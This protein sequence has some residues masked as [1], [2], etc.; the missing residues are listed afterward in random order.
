M[1][2]NT[3]MANATKGIQTFLFMPYSPLRELSGPPA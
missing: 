1:T 2:V 3:T